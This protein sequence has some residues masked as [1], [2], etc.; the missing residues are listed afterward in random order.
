MDAR[1][2][3][4]QDLYS[5]AGACLAIADADDKIVGV[6][7]LASA[8]QAHRLT[9]AGSATPVEPIGDAGRPPRPALVPPD[10]VPLRTVAT[11]EGRG[12][13]LHAVAHIEFNAVN[14]AL[15]AVYRFRGLPEAYYA[16]WIGVAADEA[17]HFELIRTELRRF[18]YEY[19][20][21]PA[22]AGLWDLARLTAGDVLARMALVPRL[23]EARG[24]DATPPIMNKFR[25]I[26]ERSVVAAL[27][28]ILREEVGHVA[29]GDRWFRYL[30]A[31]RGLE[32]MVT[33]RR[34][35]AE[36]GAPRPRR[37]FN[38]TA[39]LA[40]GFSVEELRALAEEGIQP[41]M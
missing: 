20:D 16:G 11:I 9:W 34:L 26:G 21:F 12:A 10:R 22:H 6:E 7:A 8:W 25:G 23:M 15:D 2:L 29:L 4:E 17:R 32:P 28:T 30:C 3:K 40:A 36:Y 24:L 39:R 35:I 1:D 27:E 19:G 41:A 31:E 13:L 37:P 5:A 18:G 33:Y 14:L 38:E